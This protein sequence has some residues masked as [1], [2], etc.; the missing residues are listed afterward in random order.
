MESLRQRAGIEIQRGN[1]KSVLGTVDTVK[2][3]DKQ[4]FIFE[5]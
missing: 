2:Q 4:F 1:A 3:R 5:V